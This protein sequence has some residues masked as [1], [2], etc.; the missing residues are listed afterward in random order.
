M[1][2]PSPSGAIRTCLMITEML[3]VDTLERGAP[4]TTAL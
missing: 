4:L 2:I 1:E 3:G